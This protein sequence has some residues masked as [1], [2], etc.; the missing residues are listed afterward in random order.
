MGTDSRLRGWAAAFALAFVALPAQAA[1]APTPVE[2][3]AD[4]VAKLAPFVVWPAAVFA[5]PAAPLVLCVQADDAF[6]ALLDKL[7][8]G[9]SVGAHPVVVRKTPRLG[10][11]SGCQI[12]YVAGSP[13]QTPAA[14][15]KA[16][17]GQPVLTVTD[18]DSDTGAKGIVNLVAVDGRVRFVIDA[19]RAT[20]SGLT[21]SSKLLALAADVKR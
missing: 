2:V 7:T 6:A 13:A 3:K 1:D 14:A 8:T 5:A 19:A 21:I 16:V 10:A 11:D 20:Q 9:Q 12:A 18:T 15:L 4:Y 17:D